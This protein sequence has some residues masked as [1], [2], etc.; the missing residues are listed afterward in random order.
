[1]KTILILL[2]LAM[3]GC[4]G[5]T[6]KGEVQQVDYDKLQ[7]ELIEASKQQHQDET[8]AIKKWIRKQNWPMEESKTGLHYWIYQTSTGEQAKAGLIAVI[9][10]TSSLTDGT[11]CYQTSDADPVEFLIGQD[12]VESGLHEALLLMKTGEHAKLVLP[13]HLAF[14]FTG[15]SGK[16]PQNATVVYDLHLIALK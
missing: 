9:S 13:S 12:N 11:V 4:N 6:R 16:I 7:S 5:C 3:A 15:D 1:M 8:E 2:G 14:G 10:Y